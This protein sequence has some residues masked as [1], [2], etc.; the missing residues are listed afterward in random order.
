MVLRGEGGENGRL[1]LGGVVCQHVMRV[2][3]NGCY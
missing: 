1:P 2:P 3:D